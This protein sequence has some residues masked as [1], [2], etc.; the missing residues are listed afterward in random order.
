MVVNSGN[1]NACTGAQGEKNAIAMCKLAGRLVSAD[2]HEFL[3][4]ST[5]I[6]GHQLPM[7]KVNA[8]IEQAAGRLGDSKEHALSSPMRS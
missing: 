4:S 5:G 1:A 7:E 3:P 2:P 6:I 8:G